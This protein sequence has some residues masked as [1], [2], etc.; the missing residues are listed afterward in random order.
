M[1]CFL[2][3]EPPSTTSSCLCQ[4]ICLTQKY[5]LLMPHAE[6]IKDFVSFILKG[7]L[8]ERSYRSYKYI[9]FTYYQSLCNS[10]NL[11][12]VQCFSNSLGIW[13]I[14]RSF[15]RLRN[16]DSADSDNKES[17]KSLIFGIFYQDFS[18]IL[19]SRLVFHNSLGKLH[20]CKD[21]ECI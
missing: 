2:P 12:T 13:K 11:Y 20:V 19:Y 15:K 9:P 16:H 17:V 3:P 21:I 5:V 6:T 4:S 18:I 8:Y 7:I 14:F 10:Y 1:P